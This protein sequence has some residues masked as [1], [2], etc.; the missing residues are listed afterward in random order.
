MTRWVFDTNTIVSALLFS[1]S[2]PGQAMIRALGQGT[3]LIS[4]ALAQELQDVL[5]RH[6]FDRYVSRDE[7]D[8]FL[9]ALIRE[10][11]LVEIT[12]SVQ[13]CRDPKDDKILELAV[14]GNADCVVTGDNDLLI[15]NP[16]RGVAIITPGKFLRV[17]N[18]EEGI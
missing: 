9:R 14:S 4:T 5:N 12:E 13:A 15:L 17:A 6:R 7:R 10:A 11:E 3:I 16:F 8:E 18:L 2:V 1:D